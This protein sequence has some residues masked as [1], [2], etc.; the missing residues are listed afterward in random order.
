MELNRALKNNRIFRALT[1]ITPEEFNQ[2]LPLFTKLL[3][4]SALSK[5]GRKRAYG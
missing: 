1:G 5:K 3:I 2:L 4:E